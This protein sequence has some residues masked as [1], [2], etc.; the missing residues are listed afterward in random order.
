MKLLCLSDMTLEVAVFVF[1]SMWN[2]HEFY[3]F[4]TFNA[5]A[6]FKW[7][8]YLLYIHFFVPLIII[9]KANS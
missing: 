6:L 2:I 3:T 5:E 8:D 1:T 7:D 9:V 4:H